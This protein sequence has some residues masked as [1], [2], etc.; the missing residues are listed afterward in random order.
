MT[1]CWSCIYGK[2]LDYPWISSISLCGLLGV[3]RVIAFWVCQGCGDEITPYHTSMSR[4]SVAGN[5][6]ITLTWRICLPKDSSFVFIRT[7]LIDDVNLESAATTNANIVFPNYQCAT[8][9]FIGRTPGNRTKLAEEPT[10]VTVVINIQGDYQIWRT[11]AKLFES[12]VLEYMWDRG[13]LMGKLEN[14]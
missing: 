8:F 11:L 4:N 5:I 10:W 13:N 7:C 6:L 2:S 3:K 1:L 14:L 12:M 9:M